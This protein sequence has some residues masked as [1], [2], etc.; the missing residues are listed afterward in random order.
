MRRTTAGPNKGAT[1]YFGLQWLCGDATAKGQK[2]RRTS[3]S[4]KSFS[5]GD[6]TLGQDERSFEEVQ[7]PKILD[8]V[9]VTRAGLNKGACDPARPNKGAAVS[10]L[11][12]GGD[13][14]VFNDTVEN[15]CFSS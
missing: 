8:F 12:G 15:M 5:G 7:S 9:G 14:L 3:P 11:I 13:I 6:G 10:F 4:S 1:V 2:E